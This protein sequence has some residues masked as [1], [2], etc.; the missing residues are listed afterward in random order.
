MNAISTYCFFD[1]QRVAMEQNNQEECFT[2]KPYCSVSFT[3]YE[4]IYAP[5]YRRLR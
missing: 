4:E 2:C 1:E 3:Y 5:S